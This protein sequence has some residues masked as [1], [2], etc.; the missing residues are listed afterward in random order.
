MT[1]TP[2]YLS[3]Y[4]IILVLYVC[5]IKFQCC[6]RNTILMQMGSKVP[7]HGHIIIMTLMYSMSGCAWWAIVS[8][9]KVLFIEHL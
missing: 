8:P 2:Y 3:L 6:Q 4:N 1:L 9:N 5:T 7:I